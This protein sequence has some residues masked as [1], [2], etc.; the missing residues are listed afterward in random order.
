MR[1]AAQMDIVPADG[2]G[3]DK[4]RRAVRRSVSLNA[5]LRPREGKP[6]DV[7]VLDLSSLGF[8]AECLSSFHPGDHVWL[9]LPGLETLYARVAWTDQAF[10]GCE[11]TAPI[12]PAVIEM[13]LAS[14]SA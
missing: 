6:A 13:V 10:I 3:D 11:F 2:V 1:I 8:R 4:G 5:K 14:T 9:K 7:D 12:H